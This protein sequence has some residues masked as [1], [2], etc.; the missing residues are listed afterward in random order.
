MQQYGQYPVLL[1]ERQLGSGS[2]ID[3]ATAI[4]ADELVKRGLRVITASTLADVRF[5][6]ASNSSIGAALLDWD[7]FGTVR[8]LLGVI[9]RLHR[10]NERLP[11]IL[12]AERADV[13]SIP[14]AIAEQIDGFFWLHEDTPAFVAGRVERI[15]RTYADQLFPPF[16]GALKRYVDDYNWV[17]CCPGHNGGMFYRKTPLGRLRPNGYPPPPHVAGH[18]NS[19]IGCLCANTHSP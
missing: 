4:L 13:E 9:D 17:W 10:L 1:A 2:A 12:L 3:K 19:H 18:A 8:E 15:V 5:A 16:F 7:L 14:L 6:I 11:V